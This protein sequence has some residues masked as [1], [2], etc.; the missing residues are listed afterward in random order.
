MDH[1]AFMH[2]VKM[3]ISSD[4][5]CPALKSLA[6]TGH[7]KISDWSLEIFRGEEEG[8]DQSRRLDDYGTTNRIAFHFITYIMRGAEY[9]CKYL[10]RHCVGQF[11]YY[12][13][14]FI[15]IIVATRTCDL[16]SPATKGERFA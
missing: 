9:F 10:S 5:N 13:L 2:I 3:E 8:T 1:T 6:F 16:I 12:G 11:L 15:F 14:T 7:I 4:C